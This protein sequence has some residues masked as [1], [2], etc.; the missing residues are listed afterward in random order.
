M[1][2]EINNLHKTRWES[3]LSCYNF[4][5]STKFTEYFSDTSIDFEKNVDLVLGIW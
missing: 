2:V 4:S 1:D 5:K 3:T